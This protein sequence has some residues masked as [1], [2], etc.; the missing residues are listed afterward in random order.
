MIHQRAASRNIV[1]VF[2]IPALLCA[3]AGLARPGTVLTLSPAGGTVSGT[4]GATVGWGFT[5]TN[6]T[7]FLEVTSSAF[8]ASPVSP[9]FCIGPALGT[10]TDIISSE[11][12]PVIIGPSP[13]STSV[14]Q[15]FNASTPSGVGSFLIAA[16]AANGSIDQG[17]IVLTYD[18]FSVSPNSPNFNPNLDTISTDNFLTARA[19]V[20]VNLITT[21]EPGPFALFAA[22]LILL[23]V[24]RATSRYLAG[25]NCHPHDRREQSQTRENDSPSAPRGPRT[26]PLCGIPRPMQLISALQR[27]N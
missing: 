15:T 1:R 23:A 6:T 18:L 3:A 22:G 11:S 13:E 19:A 2:V 21:P 5:I 16:S 12:S 25:Q 14:T 26:L 7:D 24:V 4:Q 17:E 8:C 27:S 9:P 20:G 10:Y